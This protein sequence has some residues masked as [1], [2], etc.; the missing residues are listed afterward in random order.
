MPTGGVPATLGD[1]RTWLDSLGSG[2]PVLHRFRWQYR[3]REGAAGGRGSARIAPGDSLRLDMIGPLG[4]GRGAAFVV[5]DSQRWAEPEEEVRKVA[6]N[7]TLLWAALGVPYL[8]RE[9]DQVTRFEDQRLVGWRII[10]GADTMELARFRGPP[11]RLVASVRQAGEVVG[12]VETVFLPEGGL[13]SSRLDV[14]SVPARLQLTYYATTRSGGF[15]PET[16]LPPER[17]P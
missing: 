14:P 11:V 17:E 3:D 8:P 2:A 15:A 16:W 10:H 4:A 6:P 1:A 7:Y 13:K 12:R 9:A 5:G